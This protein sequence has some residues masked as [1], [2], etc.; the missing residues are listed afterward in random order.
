M[1][2]NVRPFRVPRTQSA[3]TQFR[4]K[5]RARHAA[6]RGSPLCARGLS[7]ICTHVQRAAAR[8]SIIEAVC[9]RAVQT[10]AA[11]E[12]CWERLNMVHGDL[13]YRRPG[14]AVRR[15]KE[16]KAEAQRTI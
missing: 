7:V 5:C 3:I 6:G 13:A 8:P 10:A 2:S 15:F 1:I 16:R 11:C 9:A 12:F 14:N 4:L